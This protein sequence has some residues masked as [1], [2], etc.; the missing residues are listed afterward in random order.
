MSTYIPREHLIQMCNTSLT[1]R[2]ICRY[3]KTYKYNL[4]C[5]LIKCRIWYIPHMISILFFII[6]AALSSS[7]MNQHKLN[8]ISIIVRIR[9]VGFTSCFYFIFILSHIFIYLFI[10]Q[11]LHWVHYNCSPILLPIFLTQLF[12]IN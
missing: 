6:W 1:V 8:L 11:P 7:N 3:N 9:I 5:V 12:I 4:Y 10:Y 2:K